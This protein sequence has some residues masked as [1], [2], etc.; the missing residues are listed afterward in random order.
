[1]DAISRD[2]KRESEKVHFVLLEAIGKSRV[3]EIPISE[4]QGAI[5]DI[6]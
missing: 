3:V 6:C 4:L 5:D 2:K 1:M